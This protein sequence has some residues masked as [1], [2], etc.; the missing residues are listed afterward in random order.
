MTTSGELLKIAAARIVDS[1]MHKEA[2]D[3]LSSM[4]DLFKMQMLMK[5]MQEQ[6]ML[7]QPYTGAPSTSPAAGPGPK[8][9]YSPGKKIRPFSAMAKKP[10][11]GPGPRK[12][13]PGMMGGYSQAKMDALK[14]LYQKQRMAN[15]GRRRPG[16]APRALERLF[17]FLEKVRD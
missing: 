10:P 2:R 9:P 12:P 16:P 5:M 6:G 1:E 8:P 17:N 7:G 14:R 11:W 13:R 3:I 4:M 15:P